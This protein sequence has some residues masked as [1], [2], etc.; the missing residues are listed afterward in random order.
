MK[1]RSVT[2][3]GLDV[4]YKFSSVTMRDQEGNVVARQRL[5]HRDRAALRQVL[6][7]WPKGVPAVLEASFGWGWL[8]DELIAAGIEVRLS[9]CYKVEQMR[10]AR[11]WPKNNKKDGDLQSLLPGEADEWWRIWLPPAEVR[12]RREWMRYRGDLVAMQTQTKSRIHAVFHRHGVFH[13]FSDL[14]GG[15]GRAFLAELCREGRHEGGQ[16]PSGA[17]T[18]LRGLVRLLEQLRAQLAEIAGR[19]RPELEH[20]ELT[21]RLASIP[22]FGRILSHVLKAEVGQLE[23]FGGSHQRLAS[24]SLLG[25]RALDTGEQDPSR[26]PL[27]RHLGHRGHRT[28]KWAFIEAAHAAVRHGGRFKAIFDRVT[29]G[30]TKDR[31]RGYIRVARELVKVVTAVWK[32]GTTYQEMPPARPGSG[33]SGK[34]CGSC[35]GCS[36]ATRAPSP[37]KQLEKFMGSTRSG[38]GQ[39]YHPM[40]PAAKA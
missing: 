37:R 19:L 38:T 14:F 27:G 29:Q 9:N 21:R 17:L 40:V 2:A 25:P 33:H 28:L 32:N 36:K 26:T 24:Y 1:D 12:D 16:L 10:K 20:D 23:R 39:L 6:S 18:A 4:H 34:A 15:K 8:S 11:G 5:E 30:G 35:D 3:I 22:G 7:G 31:N 13:D